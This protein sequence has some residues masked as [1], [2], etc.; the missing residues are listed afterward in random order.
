[1]ELLRNNYSLFAE[2]YKIYL[3]RT[4]F[5]D[6]SIKKYTSFLEL[7][8]QLKTKKTN[9]SMKLAK[10]AYINQQFETDI[11]RKNMGTHQVL[12]PE[13]IQKLL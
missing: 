3:V 11:G 12:R 13:F 4:D 10:V 8:Q 9:P 5:P 1:M 6:T 2:A 7:I